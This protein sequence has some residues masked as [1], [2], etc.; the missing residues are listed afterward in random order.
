MLLKVVYWTPSQL[1]VEHIVLLLGAYIS[2]ADKLLNKML[3]Y[4]VIKKSS[5]CKCCNSKPDP[6]KSVSLLLRTT[7]QK[8]SCEGCIRMQHLKDS[9]PFTVPTFWNANYRPAL[10]VGNITSIMR[11][12]LRLSCHWSPFRRLLP[13]FLQFF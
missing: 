2:S 1:L 4:L 11:W 3:W 9:G 12:S 13:P 6:C 8:Q 10:W 5:S 7:M